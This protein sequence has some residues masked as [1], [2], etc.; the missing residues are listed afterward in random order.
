MNKT[1]DVK[2]DLQNVVDI[3]KTN[4]EGILNKKLRVPVQNL[5]NVWK[6]MPPTFLA[7]SK[8]NA[9]FNK[10][11]V[12]VISQANLVDKQNPKIKKKPNNITPIQ[13]AVT[14]N[15]I[16]QAQLPQVQNQ[17]AAA[18]LNANCRFAQNNKQIDPTNIY[19]SMKGLK[20]QLNFC[21]MIQKP[22]ND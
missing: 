6:S 21:I 19:N 17:K 9:I 15:A 8:L 10:F 16:P 3:G 20:Q 1:A 14:Q 4:P 11:I 13:N 12:E 18:W 22:D 5:L 7:N 2:T